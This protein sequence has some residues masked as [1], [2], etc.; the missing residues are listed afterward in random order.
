MNQPH[1]ER[2]TN[3][4]HWLIMLLCCLLP[5][6]AIGAI[7]LFDVPV[8]TVLFAGLLLFCPLSHLLMM[9]WMGRNHHRSLH[10]GTVSEKEE[11][12]GSRELPVPQ[13]EVRA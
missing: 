2:K 10:Q 9:F 13:K 6:V 8:S 4:G 1:S 11:T 7:L 12:A 3:I 5:V